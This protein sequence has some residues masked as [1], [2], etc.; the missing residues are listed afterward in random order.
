MSK[1]FHVKKK[2]EKKEDAFKKKSS[3]R[4]LLFFAVL[5]TFRHP[6]FYKYINDYKREL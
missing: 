3:S 6:C 1:E 2:N 4:R 5:Y